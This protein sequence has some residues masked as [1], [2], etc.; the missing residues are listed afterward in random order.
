VIE[1]RRYDIKS[2]HH[3]D[4]TQGVG[5][6]GLARMYE[7]SRDPGVR[8]HVEHWFRNRFDEP[9]VTKTINTM[10]PMLALAHLAGWSADDSWHPLLAEWA[11]WA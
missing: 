2:W 11:E 10:A 8:A 3:W 6:Y 5:L 9:A 1:G 4:W 7:R